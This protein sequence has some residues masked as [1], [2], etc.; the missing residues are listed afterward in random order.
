MPRLKIIAFDADD[1]LWHNETFYQQAK[2][3][4]ISILAPYATGEQVSEEL[5]KVEGRNL[6]TFGY[7]IKSFVLSMIETAVLLSGK[8]IQGQEVQRVLDLG[9]EMLSKQMEVFAGVEPTLADLSQA[10]T[11]MIITKGDLLDQETKLAR[12]GLARYFEHLEVVSQKNAETYQKIL[13]RHQVA[14]E[15]FLMVGNSLRSDI[16]PVNQIGGWTVYIPYEL[17]WAHENHIDQ[18]IHPG[19]FFEIESIDGLP[20]LLKTLS[21]LDDPH[22]E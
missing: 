1:T 13:Q 22:K 12:S 21:T 10:Y 5:D 11:L 17:T 20:A 6:P 3:Q 9:K 2:D 16:L 19:R 4:L 14:P 15:Q 18:E 7:G 8:K